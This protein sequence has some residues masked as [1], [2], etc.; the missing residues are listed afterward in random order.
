MGFFT[1]KAPKTVNT[2]YATFTAEL[3][4]VTFQHQTI[5]DQA[6]MEQ[7]NL[8]EERK[9]LASKKDTQKTRQVMAEA[10]VSQ[11]KIAMDNIGEMLG[12]KTKES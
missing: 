6:K 1:K 10:E 5:A 3:E 4:E 8:E 2:V 9:V 12:I 7:A 11:A